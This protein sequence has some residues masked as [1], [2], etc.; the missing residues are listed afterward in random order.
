M[1]VGLVANPASGKDVRRVTAR[2]SVFDNQ[3]KTAMLR[4]CLVGIRAMS[5]APIRYLPDPHRVASSAVD[6]LGIEAE[7]LD[8]AIAASAEDTTRAAQALRGARAVVVLGGD[9]TNRA[10]AKGWLDA[11]LIPLSTGTNNA[12]P[13]MRE[14]TTA[15]AAAGLLANGAPLTAVAE[16]AKVIHVRIEGEPGDLALIDAVF[17]ADRFVGARALDDPG[18]FRCALLTRADPAG[19]GMTSVGGFARPLGRREDAA[20]ALGFQGAGAGAVHAALAPGRFARIALSRV[21]VFALG[22]AMRVR[23]PGVLA[24]D[25]ERERVLQPGQTATLWAKRD[26]P[27]VVDVAKVLVRAARCRRNTST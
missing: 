22:R 19:V 18:R 8:I 7:P 9:G 10:F 1:S 14:A 20:L 25:G 2:A 13:V 17:T 12:F 16:Q 6:E 3:E 15:G 4:R 23:G 27:W 11:P 21:D 5:E 26:G 24:F